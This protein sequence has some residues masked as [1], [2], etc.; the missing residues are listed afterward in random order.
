MHTLPAIC[1]VCPWKFVKSF[2]FTCHRFDHRI[3]SE[4]KSIIN[5]AETSELLRKELFSSFYECIAHINMKY[6]KKT[7]VS[8]SY[9][10][11]DNV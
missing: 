11:I 8:N 6:S 3:N 10:K 2:A 7:N 9:H 4:L 5:K 1:Y